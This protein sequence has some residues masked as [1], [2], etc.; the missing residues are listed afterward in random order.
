MSLYDESHCDSHQLSELLQLINANWK[1]IMKN[2]VIKEYVIMERCLN[3]LQNFLELET[4]EKKRN[5]STFL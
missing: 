2:G 3:C 4:R 5:K 1:N